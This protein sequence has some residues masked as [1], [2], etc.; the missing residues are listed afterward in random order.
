MRAKL[1]LHTFF[2][3]L[4]YSN[5]GFDKG[6]EVFKHTVYLYW[7]IF[8]EAF[9]A[10]FTV[11]PIN[12]TCFLFSSILDFGKRSLKGKYIGK[13]VG[14]AFFKTSSICPG[15]LF[16]NFI[17]KLLRLCDIALPVCFLRIQ[18][19]T[20]QCVKG[21][22]HHLRSKLYFLCLKLSSYKQDTDVSDL[23]Y[24][25]KSEVLYLLTNNA[26]YRNYH[27][28]NKMTRGIY[29]KLIQCVHD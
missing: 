1:V 10:H 24:V 28:F 11:K 12:S 3:F 9:V 5:T 22:R 7:Q 8:N 4:L 21:H 18:E 29:D 27:F 20:C 16:W 2:K 19:N 25:N 6:Y 23:C 13:V 15:I 26:K 17:Y 14:C